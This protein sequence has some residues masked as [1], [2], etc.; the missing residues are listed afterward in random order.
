MATAEMA[1]EW[2]RETIEVPEWTQPKSPPETWGQ[3]HGAS[4][5]QFYQRLKAEIEQAK[6]ILELHEDWDGEGS[7]GYSEETLKRAIDFLDTHVEQLW[8]SFGFRP[9]IPRIGPGPD[10]SVDLHWKD[11]SWE[12]LVNIPRDINK[13]AAF[14]GDDYGVQ[15]IR[16]TVESQKFNLVIAAWLMN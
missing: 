4:N 9:P 12:L 1:L 5:I 11:A 6:R 10:G 15:K 14:Y 16:G 8:K 7:P 3:V 2:Q 13:M